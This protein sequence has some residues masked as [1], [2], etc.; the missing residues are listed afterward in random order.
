MKNRVYLVKMRTTMY[1]GDIPQDSVT[2]LDIDDRFRS[3]GLPGLGLSEEEVESI[4][5]EPHEMVYRDAEVEATPYGEKRQVIRDKT[6]YWIIKTPYSFAEEK[7]R[8]FLRGLEIMGIGRFGK[9]KLLE[10]TYLG[11][12]FEDN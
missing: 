4:E 3:A 1:G 10:F 12:N 7:I 9:F 2:Q 11:N 5:I 6:L 8:K